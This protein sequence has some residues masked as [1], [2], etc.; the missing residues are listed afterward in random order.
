MEAAQ[1]S[2]ISSSYWTEGVGPTAALATLKKLKSVDVPSRLASISERFRTGLDDLANLQG[3]NIHF[4]GHPAITVLSFE[5]PQASALQTLFTVRMLEEGI[6]VGS[7]FYASLSHHEK[8]VDRFLEAADKVLPEVAH[9]VENGDVLK[10]IPNGVKHSG[11]S[12]LT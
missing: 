1:S 4:Y 10:R 5:H 11:F 7:G 8:H 6:L 3:L 2:F 9:A 12:R